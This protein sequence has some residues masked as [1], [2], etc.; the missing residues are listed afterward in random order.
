MNT[1]RIELNDVES[2]VNILNNGGVVAFPTDTV[3]GLGCRFDNLE[4]IKALKKAK[5]RDENKPLPFM[6]SH[7]KDI[8]NVAY[9][10]DDALKVINKLMPGALTV[11]LKKKEDVSDYITNGFDTIGIRIPDDDYVL[12]II[13]SCKVPL[14]V[15]SANK[16]N[17]PTGTTSTEVLEQLDGLID[18]VVIG[19]SAMK[20]AST[21]VNLIDGVRIVREGPIDLKTIEDTI[22]EK[23]MKIAL[24]ADHGGYAYKELLKKW[25]LE[26]GYEVKDFGGY[27]SNPIDYPDVAY[28]CAKAVADKEFDRGIMICGTGI[29]VSIV[30]NKVKGIRCALCSDLFSAKATR[31]H[32]DSN[33]LAMGGRV[34]TEEMMFSIAKLWLET[35]FSNEERH[36]NRINKITKIENM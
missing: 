3:Y 30:A 28:P 6:C 25:L 29:G 7:I 12:N 26:N 33:V 13:N 20:R 9:V 8:N 35:P 11:I 19:E 23:K 5:G 32:N 2:V 27:E 34:I 21:I 14:L 31:E 22:K 4:A 36:I 17:M 15:T 1:K 16:S 10:S 18:G 24:A